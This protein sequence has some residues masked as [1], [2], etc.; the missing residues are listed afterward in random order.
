MTEIYLHVL[1]AHYEHNL[2]LKHEPNQ[3]Q[4]QNQT[5]NNRLDNALLAV[6]ARACE[7]AGARVRYTTAHQLYIGKKSTIYVAWFLCLKARTVRILAAVPRS[8]AGEYC[9]E[10]SASGTQSR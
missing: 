4:T 8:A 7:R 2:S 5:H 9:G 1:C 6:Y 10:A 3:T